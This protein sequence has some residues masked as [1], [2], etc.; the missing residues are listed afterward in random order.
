MNDYARVQ[1]ILKLWT[2]AISSFTEAVN[3]HKLWCSG[4]SQ[5]IVL[6]RKSAAV[7]CLMIWYAL[8]DPISLAPDNIR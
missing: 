6:Q 1:Y 5:L 2:V 7:R 4:M 8:K 3:L